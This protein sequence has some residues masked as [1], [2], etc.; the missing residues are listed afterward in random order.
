[1]E[2]NQLKVKPI[3]EIVTRY[4]FRFY[5]VDKPGVLSV[6]SGVLGSH[7]ISL[8][9]V[10]QKG[11]EVRGAVP[12]VMLSHEAKGA[13]VNAALAQIDRLDVVKDKTVVFRVED[14]L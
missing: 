12:L 2:S 13:D 7:N 11:R 8:S 14:R 3:D 4:Y 6:I 10:L 9:S 1:M 5:A